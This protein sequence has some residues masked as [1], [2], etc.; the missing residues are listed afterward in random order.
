MNSNRNSRLDF[1]EIAVYKIFTLYQL[2]ERSKEYKLLLFLSSTDRKENEYELLYLY[3]IFVHHSS[4]HTNREDVGESYLLSSM[5][6]TGCLEVV[7]R[8]L[9]SKDE[10]SVNGKQLNSSLCEQYWWNKWDAAR[11]QSKKQGSGPENSGK[12]KVMQSLDM[13]R[14]NLQV[15]DVDLE[16]GGNYIYLGRVTNMSR[17]LLADVT[18]RSAAGCANSVETSSTQSVKSV[19][20]SLIPS[21][22]KQ[23]HTKRIVTDEFHGYINSHTLGQISGMK[24]IAV[25]S[26]ES[27]IRWERHIALLT[28][29]GRRTSPSAIRGKENDHSAG[30]HGSGVMGEL[31]DRD[32][33]HSAQNWRS[34]NCCAQHGCISFTAGAL[35]WN[36]EWYWWLW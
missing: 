2:F 33:R 31:A 17:S 5:L 32:W 15:G 26:K 7:F 8:K 36:S 29:R 18:S 20:T 19:T 4:S 24:D 13:P 16:E 34:W 27:K 30:L 6:F 25:A 14:A 9:N 10:I 22:W 21:C 28:T 3:N 23:R 1:E 35:H 12:T 11:A